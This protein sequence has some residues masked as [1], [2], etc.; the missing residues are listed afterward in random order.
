M[1]MNI[2]VPNTFRQKIF[3]GFPDMAF[4]GKAGSV[5]HR[6]FRYSSAAAGSGRR[7]KGD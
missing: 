4:S 3:S 1:I 2:T 7:G 6:R 5:L